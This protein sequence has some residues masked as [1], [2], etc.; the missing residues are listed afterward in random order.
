MLCTRKS[1]LSFLSLL[2]CFSFTAS[3]QKLTWK[4]KKE[5]FNKGKITVYDNNGKVRGCFE[6]KFLP[7]FKSTTED[8]KENWLNA[9]DSLGDLVNC[10]GFW[11]KKVFGDVTDGLKTVK[12]T[13]K[14]CGISKIPSDFRYMRKSNENATGQF[15]ETA[16]KLL[17]GISFAASAVARTGVSLAGGVYGL[18]YAAVVPTVRVAAKVVLPVLQATGLGTVL[19]TLK[20]IWNGTAWVLTQ[21][22]NLPKESTRN[23]MV[24]FVPYV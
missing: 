22:S 12:R 19:P 3:A 7:G 8:A 15:G 17:N 24:R 1:V 5:L 9:V 14:K 11:N 21:G 13:H 16:Q 6:V 10:E 2:L 20:Y 23:F 4:Q 18:G